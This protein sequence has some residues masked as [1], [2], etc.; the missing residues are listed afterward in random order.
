MD[1]ANIEPDN[2]G[3]LRQ[4]YVERR[5]VELADAVV[6]PSRYMIGW[7]RSKGWELPDECMVIQNFLRG[8][9]LAGLIRSVHALVSERNQHLAFFGRLERR[10]GIFLFLEALRT[11]PLA[12]LTFKLSFVGREADINPAQVANWLSQQRPD[13]LPTVAFLPNKTA[14]EAREYLNA[15]HALAVIPSL[16]DNLP[17]V[18]WECIEDGIPFVSTITGGIPE[19]IPEEAHARVLVEPTPIALSERLVALLAK[20]PSTRVSHREDPEEIGRRWLSWLRL[21]PPQSGI[22][23]PTLARLSV[24]VLLLHRGNEEQLSCRLQELSLQ[25]D[26]QFSL[27][28]V[29]PSPA[30]EPMTMVMSALRPHWIWS[31]DRRLKTALQLIDTETS[32]VILCDTSASLSPSLVE[33]LRRGASAFPH[34]VLA[35]HGL[36]VGPGQEADHPFLRRDVQRSAP[37]GGDTAAGAYENVFGEFPVALPAVA[38]N[39]DWIPSNV[40]SAWG[41]LAAWSVRGGTVEVLPSALVCRSVDGEAWSYVSVREHDEVRRVYMAMLPPHL[42]YLLA[43][44]P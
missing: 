18:I 4:M 15:T 39:A 16:S 9:H 22:N 37:T 12:N 27:F 11:P 21:E 32:L 25:T 34:S 26:V 6:S 33:E 43:A 8:L 7:M 13:L 38:A 2:R 3:A 28:I 19:L 29:S 35:A 23:L 30:P 31:E 14:D 10:K 20:S 44:N 17:C 24:T 41:L 1:V 42:K 36:R 40:E 5:A